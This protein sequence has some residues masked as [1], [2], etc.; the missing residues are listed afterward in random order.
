MQRQKKDKYL[1]IDEKDSFFSYKPKKVKLN[2]EIK[3]KHRILEMEKYCKEMLCL[4][5]NEITNQTL[6]VFFRDNI[7]LNFN[8]KI[9]GSAVTSIYS[10]IE[11]NDIDLLVKNEREQE[12]F[13]NWMRCVYNTRFRSSSYNPHFI[14]Y[15]ATSY[16]LKHKFISLKFDII[17]KK[18]FSDLPSDFIQ[19]NICIGKGG[20]Q[21]LR[22]HNDVFSLK[23]I[24]NDLRNKK[25]TIDP[26]YK[27]GSFDEKISILQR[28]Y[29][30]RLS[31]YKIDETYKVCPGSECVITYTMDDIE[32]MIKDMFASD[33]V[34]IV[35]SY[36]NRQ[37]YD[38]NDICL[39]CNSP[40][41]IT[42]DILPFIKPLKLV[43]LIWNGIKSKNNVNKST[44]NV[45]HLHCFRD[46][47][48]TNIYL[49]KNCKLN[50]NT[51]IIPPNKKYDD[52]SYEYFM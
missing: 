42:S 5:C 21:L 14:N 28:C 26:L 31:G 27:S 18:K 23:K 20:L 36:L 33:V 49:K 37:V 15:K 13:V 39:W 29:K 44:N 34:K 6:I 52:E 46:M 30:K 19:S 16:I 8:I 1:K 4:P 51:K 22:P 40:F 9:F 47:L 25:L 24:K 17:L 7:P 48:N 3:A 38:K 45:Y 41:D 10:K 32:L 43:P 2:K 35:L 50:L 11:P 12:R